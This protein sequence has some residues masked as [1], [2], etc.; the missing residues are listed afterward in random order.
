MASSSSFDFLHVHGWQR[1][2]VKVNM[3][4]DNIATNPTTNNAYIR[5]SLN[6]SERDHGGTTSTSLTMSD[7]CNKDSISLISLT[8][9]STSSID[10]LSLEKFSLLIRKNNN[11]FDD[12]TNMMVNNNEQRNNSGD[13][14]STHNDYDKAW[15]ILSHVEAKIQTTPTQKKRTTRDDHVGFYCLE[16][17]SFS[18]DICSS[19]IRNG[20]FLDGKKERNSEKRGRL[21]TKI[22][23]FL[24]YVLELKN[25]FSSPLDKTSK[26]ILGSKPIHYGV[27]RIKSNF[28]EHST[29]QRI[30]K[31]ASC[32]DLIYNTSSTIH[33]NRIEVV[34][35][36]FLSENYLCIRF[37]TGDTYTTILEHPHVLNPRL[38]DIERN[39]ITTK[40]SRINLSIQ[41][42]K[43]TK[44]SFSSNYY[45][46]RC[47]SIEDGAVKRR[48]RK[49]FDV[50]NDLPG[51]KSSVN[52]LIHI[53]RYLTL[54]LSLI[55]LTCVRLSP[56]SV[57]WKRSCL[58]IHTSLPIV[59]QLLYRH[60]KSISIHSINRVIQLLHPATKN[61]SFFF[62]SPGNDKAG[63]K[64]IAKLTNFKYA[65][66]VSIGR[67]PVALLK[68]V[69]QTIKPV[70]C[71]QLTCIWNALLR[72]RRQH[73]VFNSIKMPNI[74][75][76][77]LSSISFCISSSYRSITSSSSFKVYYPSM[78]S[79]QKIAF[80]ALL[81]WVFLLL[82]A[83]TVEG[84]GTWDN[85]SK[86]LSTRSVYITKKYSKP[87]LPEKEEN[88]PVQLDVFIQTISCVKD[89]KLF[90]NI[91]LK[92]TIVNVIATRMNERYSDNITYT[93]QGPDQ[94]T[95]PVSRELFSHLLRRPKHCNED[96][97]SIE[98]HLAF[99][100]LDRRYQYGQEATIDKDKHMPEQL[101]RILV[102]CHI[103]SMPISICENYGTS[104]L[105]LSNQHHVYP[106]ATKNVK[107]Y[108]PPRFNVEE[109]EC[110]ANHDLVSSLQR[111]M[112]HFVSW[113]FFFL[114]LEGILGKL[115][116]LLTIS[117]VPIN[118]LFSFGNPS[119]QNCVIKPEA[120]ILSFITLMSLSQYA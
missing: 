77:K 34:S 100:T 78:Y 83:L 49:F 63:T 91:S 51:E 43:S 102:G 92:L 59:I 95:I 76:R 11:E 4:T 18:K 30:P 89:D 114:S 87:E 35:S 108:P 29:T 48:K 74:I 90:H 88:N 42:P 32:V 96:I 41:G 21:K 17:F 62:L 111:R 80:D 52:V 107:N 28:S 61:C 81:F 109:W 56:H 39:E 67:L 15:G 69:I 106:G 66:I 98:N 50:L 112:N 71:N 36:E 105:Q 101:E 46:I 53:Y 26:Q 70:L 16:A 14:L 27:K 12:I 23:Y 68:L 45:I 25:N 33:D 3:K 19:E 7:V 82:P 110:N 44:D 37:H 58:G 9:I 1:N 8:N 64:D 6:D 57:S 104:T 22:S 13:C 5:P 10:F 54:I 103:N 60:A 84:S 116:V 118:M 119:D 93:S 117:F 2:I 113:I 65:T 31:H 47:K 86:E 72:R 75:V 97:V 94:N 20:Q 99:N 40:E 24:P 73:E 55:V 38:R 120:W 85:R 79:N 115:D